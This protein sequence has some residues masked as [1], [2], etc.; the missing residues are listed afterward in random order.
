MDFFVRR[1]EKNM[2]V[3]ERWPLAEVRLYSKTL[4][5]ITIL[6]TF[7]S[8]FTTFIGSFQQFP[9]KMFNSH[10]QGRVSI[11]GELL[12]KEVKRLP[13]PPYPLWSSYI[14]NDNRRWFQSNSIIQRQTLPVVWRCISLWNWAKLVA[15]CNKIRKPS[16]YTRTCLA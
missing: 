7:P 5:R 4:R 14:K 9:W 10:Q 11:L 16:L 13:L 6:F 8:S 3:V 1:G 2:A 15:P 12:I